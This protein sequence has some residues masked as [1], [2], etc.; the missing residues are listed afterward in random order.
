MFAII[1][2]IW[3]MIAVLP[4]L[5]FIEI[6]KKFAKFLKEKDIYH[7]WDILHSI[8]VVLLILVI[9]LWLNGFR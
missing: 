3:W 1:F 9:I 7:H 2:K 8:L 6:S 5:I 4:F